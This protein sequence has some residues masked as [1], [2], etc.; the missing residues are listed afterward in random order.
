MSA[1]VGFSIQSGCTITGAGG[2]NGKAPRRWGGGGNNNGMGDGR[3]VVVCGSDRTMLR[4]VT[5]LVSSGEHV[6]AIVNPES[7]ARL[8][9]RSRIVVVA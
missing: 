8:M 3:G 4:V 7:R 1:P 6:T 2:D 9:L 5:E